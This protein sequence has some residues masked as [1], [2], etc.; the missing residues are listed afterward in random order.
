MTTHQRTFSTKLHATAGT[1]KHSRTYLDKINIGE[2][3]SPP[4]HTTT[5]AEFKEAQFTRDPKLENV[6]Y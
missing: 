1:Q 3:V 2:G 5:Q 6:L 4:L